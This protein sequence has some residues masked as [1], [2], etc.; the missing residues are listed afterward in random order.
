MKIAVCS[1]LHLEFGDISL[2]NTGNADVLVLSGDIMV[3][4]DLETLND[5]EEASALMPTRARFKAERFKE[6]MFRCSREFNLVLYVAGN[7]EH[8]NGEFKDTFGLLRMAFADLKN[9]V[10]LDKESIDIGDYTFFGGT[11]WTDMNKEDVATLTSIERMMNDFRCVTNGVTNRK[12]PLY[13]KDLHTDEYIRDEKGSLI[14]NGFKYKEFEKLFTPQDAVNDHKEFLATLKTK[15]ALNPDRKFV[16]VGHHA[17]SRKSTHPR[18]KHET[19]MNGGYSSDLD[20]FII[21]NPQIKLWTHGHTHEQFD[22]MVGET[23]IV[24]NPRGYINYEKSA[25]CFELKYWD[26]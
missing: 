20:Q 7:H 12:V 19:Q 11:L 10:V 2:E 5:T 8:Y 21:D 24:C 22:Y 6:F 4:K 9:V 25:D 13:L 23:R 17:P 16:V 26:V 18:Y 14:P 1:D 15:L 3:A